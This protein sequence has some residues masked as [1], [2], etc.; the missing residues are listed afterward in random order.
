MTRPGFIGRTL[1]VIAV[2]AAGSTHAAA[3]V[4]DGVVT[5]AVGSPG[6]GPAANV[7]MNAYG[8]TAHGER[9]YLADAMG[10]VVRVIDTV[11][12]N[13]D[14]VAGFGGGGTYGAS[15]GEA[16]AY[17]D[18]G[19]GPLAALDWPTDVA[20]DANG[21][22]CISDIDAHRIRCVDPDGT[23]RT[24]A[25]TGVDASTGDGGPA[26]LADV[27]PDGI[28]FDSA[29]NLYV[30]E[31]FANRVRRITPQGIIEPFAGTG[32]Q[33][34]SGDGGPAREATFA[35][36]YDVTV[37]PAGRV[38]VADRNNLRIRRVDLDG[39]VT[40]IAGGGTRGETAAEGFPAAELYGAGT[41]GLALH[42]DGTLY[43]TGTRAVW[44]I[45]AGGILRRIAGNFTLGDS[46]D[47]GPARSARVNP[48]RGLAIDASGRVFIGD[49]ETSRVRWIDTAGII[50]P[51]G[52]NNRIYYSGDGG[53][54]TAAQ[55]DYPWDVA[56]DGA[57]GFYVVEGRRARHVPSDGTITTRAAIQALSTDVLP[58]GDLVYADAD[59]HQV[60]RVLADG[61]IVAIA[62]R[63]GQGG[64]SGDGGPATSATLN[65]PSDVTVAAD[66]SVYV[67]DHQNNRI[68]RIDP[69]GT[70][71]TVAGSGSTGTGVDADEV[72]AT[73]ARL[74]APQHVG[75]DAAGNV[76]FAEPWSYRVR[77]VGP[78]GVIHTAAGTRTA[79]FSGDGG[80]ATAARIER[81]LGLHVEPRGNV[82]IAAG[83]RIRMIDGRGTIRTLV[84]DGTCCT[85]SEP[86]QVA[87]ARIDPFGLIVDAAGRIV[88]AEFDGRRVRRAELDDFCPQLPGLDPIDSDGDGI[89][90]DCECPEG[91]ACA[92][93]GNPCT[94]D[95]CDALGDCVHPAGRAGA[96]CRAPAGACDVAETCDG[97]SAAC[98]VDAVAPSSTTCRPGAGACDVA[99]ACD[100]L[101]A[102]CPADGFATASTICRAAS[103]ECDVADHCSGAGA[104]CPA[105]AKAAPGTACTPD[106]ETCT[107][108]VCDGS[109]T[110][111]HPA[112]NAGSVCR[113]AA[114]A[115]DVAEQCD[116]T[117]PACPAD[118]FG[119]SSVVCRDAIGECDVAEHCTGSAALCPADR[120][121][122]AGTPCSPDAILCSADVCDGASPACTHPPGNAGAVC[123]PS[124][125]SCDVAERC[126]G[127]VTSC[128]DDSGLPDADDDG[129]C[130]AQDPCTNVAGAQDFTTPPRS[131][132]VLTNLARDASR[133]DD[134]L[135][136]SASFVL[137]PGRSFGDL[138]PDLRGARIVIETA[139]GERPLDV[140]VPRG[141]Y[142]L[143]TKRGWKRS[144][145]AW[146]FV[147]R[148]GAPADGVTKLSIT[149][150]ASST[151][152]RSVKVVISGKGGTYAVPPAQLPVQIR[153]ALGDQ[154]DAAAGLCGESTFGTG[155]C[156][157]VAGGNQLSCGE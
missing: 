123:R 122:T 104:T 4:A 124:T 117:A 157:L 107:R 13:A 8:M 128:P 59:A 32:S 90:D 73:Q 22:V 137:P 47:G 42:P 138:R 142:G 58:G 129:D 52:G 98:P 28:A 144:A 31:P 150:R 41:L 139:A 38:Y 3:V 105:D 35:G 65:R 68:R 11:S 116:G 75:V 97:V 131:S 113:T 26:T 80:P 10:S 85:N 27:S 55:L 146:T 23:I 17:G 69:G 86:Q 121:A 64:F 63:A 5:L 109:G 126:D 46:G 147:D 92:D 106:R 81:V 125:G 56:N 48:T 141:L 1:A 2:I 100:G 134:R 20:V 82:L 93:D 6:R 24:I 29:G 44:Q 39:T 37:D 149:D 71:T 110:C 96:T 76:Y 112:G 25:G 91:T 45:D 62:G 43:F 136:V 103:G 115:C 101:S 127:A 153:I 151:A 78:D 67:A 16:L 114:G 83:N 12:G 57:G 18:G 33:G 9:V 94:S 120:R 135:K 14:V 60:K 50:H 143:A 84:G 102:A 30:A 74:S 40:T 108:D 95:V 152:P 70:I 49:Y 111:A 54:A 15:V 154:D 119:A 21:R 155:Q 79:G 88:F 132:V 156:R 53:P 66:G 99:E 61:T 7:S 145:R 36:P 77:R 51:L 140:L 89:G 19:L 148:S 72:P 133:P 118:R 130:D 34:F 87:D